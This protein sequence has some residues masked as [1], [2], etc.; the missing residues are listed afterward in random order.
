MGAEPEKG[1]KTGLTAGKQ[2]PYA[3]TGFWPFLAVLGHFA[4]DRHL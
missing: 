4:F 2:T 1:G 3:K